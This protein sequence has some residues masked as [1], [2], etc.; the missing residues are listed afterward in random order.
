MKIITKIIQ[1]ILMIK[2]TNNTDNTNTYNK[3]N[4]YDDNLPSHAS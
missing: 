2:I 1:D 4:K 3:H